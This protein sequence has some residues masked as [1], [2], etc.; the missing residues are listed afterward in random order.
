MIGNHLFHLLSCPV[1]TAHQVSSSV[2]YWN[3]DTVTEC[4]FRSAATGLLGLQ[5]WIPLGAQVSVF[6]QC[7]ILSETFV[8]GQSIFQRSPAERV[9]V[10]EHEQV[11]IQPSLPT[12]ARLRKKER[13]GERSCL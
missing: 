3:F 10:I 9:C 8:M 7:S 2:F 1:Q 6:C 13:V 4:E 11:Q 5:V 12:E